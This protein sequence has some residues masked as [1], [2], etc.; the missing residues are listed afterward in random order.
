MEKYA[1]VIDSDASQE[2]YLRIANHF[3]VAGNHFKA[4]QFYLKAREYA[5]VIAVCC[6]P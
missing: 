2:D 3:Q 4:G 1:E 6:L 5:K